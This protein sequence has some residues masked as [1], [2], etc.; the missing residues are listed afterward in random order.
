MRLHLLDGTYELFRHYF[1]A[2]KRQAPDGREVGATRGILQ[3]FLGLLRQEDVTHVAAA[4]DTEITSFRNDL[5]DGYKTDEGVDEELL[6][7]FPLAERATQ[8]LG[9]TVWSMLEFEADDALATG[10]ARWGDAPGVEQVLLC[11]PDKDLAQCVR[12]RQVVTFDRRKRV[13]ADDDGVREKFGVSPASIPDFLGLVGDAAD[14]IPGLKGWGAKSSSVLLARYG[15]IE[16]IPDDANAWD[17]KVR[18]AAGLAATLKEQRDDALFYRRLA[19]LRTDVPLAED[20]DDLRWRGLHG[21]AFR[22]L[23][24][25][26]GAPDLAKRA[27]DLQEKP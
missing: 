18:G 5:F 10:A 3:S 14:G 15:H 21:D 4:F 20:L 17:V 13:L 16:E 19:T 24:E 7:Q 23:C 1:G 2:P 9:I 8:A 22:Q 25:E 11:S 12:G 26:I 6:Q 27:A